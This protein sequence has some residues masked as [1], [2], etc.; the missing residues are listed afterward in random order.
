[1]ERQTKVKN[2]KTDV[3][4]MKR[5]AVLRKKRMSDGQQ[6]YKPRSKNRTAISTVTINDNI[7]TYT[8]NK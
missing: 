3:P 8:L 6:F 1:M 5:G 4:S 2:I 7:V